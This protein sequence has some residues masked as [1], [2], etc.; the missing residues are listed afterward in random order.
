LVNYAKA[1]KRPFLD[2]KKLIIGI[3]LSFVP[4]INFFA[5]GYLLEC[6]KGVAVKKKKKNYALPE[7]QNWG[8]LFVSGLLFYV[9]SF[10][11][12]L[13][14]FAIFWAGMAKAM[15][16]ITQLLAA[17]NAAPQI[18]TTMGAYAITAGVLFVAL[19]YFMY[20]ALVNFAVKGK[21]KAAF[22]AEVF[23]KAFTMNYLGV[24]A[25]MML[26]WIA[27]SWLLSFVP[28][29]GAAIASFVT[30]I[31]MFTAFGE[32]YIES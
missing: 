4:I 26:F 10:I 14:P 13:V 15:G 16:G 32:A 30:G 12:M 20:M 6:A 2:I 8:S 18:I 31:I 21:F 17:K 3:L 27:T 23:K 1:F 11:Y 24:W 9:I 7:W 5:T 29:V 25:L 19:S 28:Y 22:S